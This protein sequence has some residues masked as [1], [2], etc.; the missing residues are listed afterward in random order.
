MTN[1]VYRTLTQNISLSPLDLEKLEE[2]LRGAGAVLIDLQHGL[3]MATSVSIPAPQGTAWG[4]PGARP[5]AEPPHGP[6]P[7]EQQPPFLRNDP[8]KCPAPVLPMNPAKPSGIDPA[9]AS[10]I[11]PGTAQAHVTVL[12]RDPDRDA[13]VAGGADLCT[14]RGTGGNAVAD[15]MSQ[16]MA[17]GMGPGNVPVFPLGSCLPLEIE[18]PD[19]HCQ[20]VVHAT[21]TISFGILIFS[22]VSTFFTLRRLGKQL[23]TR[24]PKYIP[25]HGDD[26]DSACFHMPAFIDHRSSL[27]KHRRTYSAAIFLTLC[28]AVVRVPA[29]VCRLE[30]LLAFSHSQ[31]L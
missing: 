27:S 8:G 31:K 7:T 6:F 18:V 10:G 26:K 23:G 15:G 13:G 21:N 24:S 4:V 29:F 25:E 5:N 12:G 2:Q 22:I 11:F 19:Q 20:Q 16:R 9:I 28:G 17:P 1:C 14:G 3:A 30:S